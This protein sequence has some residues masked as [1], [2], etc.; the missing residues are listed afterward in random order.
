MAAFARTGK[1]QR[2]G[3]SFF[4]VIPGGPEAALPHLLRRSSHRSRDLIPHRPLPP[5]GSAPVLSHAVLAAPQ[6][7]SRAPAGAPSPVAA[8]KGTQTL[9]GSVP[10][11]RQKRVPTG[12]GSAHEGSPAYLQFSILASGWQQGDT[13]CFGHGA[14]A[15]F[16]AA[17]AAIDRTAAPAS[18]GPGPGS[19]A[20][21]PVG[22]EPEG[23]AEERAKDTDGDGEKHGKHKAIHT[24]D[25]P[26]VMLSR[27]FIWDNSHKAT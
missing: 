24:P 25:P 4:P 8:R 19:P 5:P 15:A 16:L 1:Q 10:A 13:P 3:C 26:A 6:R 23:T 14:F 7:R 21:P 18:A 9:G 22:A 27:Q 17:G 12:D 20:G 2:A 11:G